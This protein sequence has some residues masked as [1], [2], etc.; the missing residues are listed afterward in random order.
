MVMTYFQISL[1]TH[2]WDSAFFMAAFPRQGRGG[3]NDGLSASRRHGR[4]DQ[5]APAFLR[6]F[7]LKG[8]AAVAFPLK[9]RFCTGP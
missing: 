6:Y 5:Q 9:F 4:P 8:R 7:A 3:G 1:P 2:N